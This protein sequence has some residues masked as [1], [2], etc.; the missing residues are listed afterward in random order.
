MKK[1]KQPILIIFFIVA[2]VFVGLLIKQFGMPNESEY[3]SIEP[4]ALHTNGQYFVGSES[5]KECHPKIY[6]EHVKTAHFNSSAV[7]NGG[8]IKGSF[9]EGNNYHYL[10]SSALFVMTEKED[11]FYQDFYTKPDSVLITSKRFDVTIGSGTKGQT[12]LNWREDELY[13]LQI[14]YYEPTHSWIN[15]PGYSNKFLSSNRQIQKRCLECHATFVESVS[16]FKK[17][18]VYKKYQMVYGIDCERCHGPAMEHV[19]LHRENT[20]ESMAL[21][22]QSYSNLSRQQKL[23]ACALCHSG[24]RVQTSSPFSFVVGDTL[25]K[26]SVPDY[27]EESL[28]SLDVHGNQYGLISASQCFIKSETMDCA[29]CHNPHKKERGNTALFNSKCVG[30]HTMGQNIECTVDSMHSTI[31]E[32]NCIQCHMPLTPSESMKVNVTK[33]SVA[34]PVMVRSHFIGIYAQASK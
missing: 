16:T 25:T 9:E 20:E 27:D 31:S 28:A 30:C 32:N 8:N 24:V 13:Q 5:C 11:G 1:T 12:Y 10:N 19:K 3:Q 34:T 17:S 22:I 23:D 6:E 14:S 15:S 21:G 29:T 18:N 7:S 2:T 26:H 33:D 4:I